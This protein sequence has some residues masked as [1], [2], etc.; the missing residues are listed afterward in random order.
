[1]ETLKDFPEDFQK[2]CQLKD[3]VT[4]SY[5]PPVLENGVFCPACVNF[6]HSI[7]TCP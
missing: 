6:T 2:Y 4:L 7:S 3:I 1:M 5:Y